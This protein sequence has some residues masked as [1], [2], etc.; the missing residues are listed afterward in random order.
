MP[1]RLPLVPSAAPPPLLCLLLP[2]LLLPLLLGAENGA[3]WKGAAAPFDWL[4][5]DHALGSD[6]VKKDRSVCTHNM[7]SKMLQK[8]VVV[9]IGYHET[10]HDT[11]GQPSHSQYEVDDLCLGVAPQSALLRQSPQLR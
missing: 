3:D 4:R 9:S 8:L 7:V 11:L 6:L 2:L 5:R 10:M 1:P